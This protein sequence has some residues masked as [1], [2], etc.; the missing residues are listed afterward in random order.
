MLPPHTSVTNIIIM[1]HDLVRMQHD[2]HKKSI[3]EMILPCAFSLYI[4]LES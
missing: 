2:F 1:E 3:T 4:A